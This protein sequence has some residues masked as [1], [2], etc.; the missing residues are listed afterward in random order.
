MTNAS[1][2]KHVEDTVSTYTEEQQLDAAMSEKIAKLLESPDKDSYKT[3]QQVVDTVDTVDCLHNGLSSEHKGSLKQSVSTMLTDASPSTPPSGKP[4]LSP[5]PPDTPCESSTTGSVTSDKPND[6]DVTVASSHNNQHGAHT[7]NGISHTNSLKATFVGSSLHAN[8][9]VFV[10]NINAP[11]FVP[12]SAHHINVASYMANGHTQNGYANGHATGSSPSA[13]SG[14]SPDAAWDEA[15]VSEASGYQNGWY[16]AYGGYADPYTG[17]GYGAMTPDGL[18]VPRQADP[19]W[20]GMGPQQGPVGYQG[21]KRSNGTQQGSKQYAMEADAALA[22][23]REQ[24]PL[25][26]QDSLTDVL[27]VNGYDLVGALDMLA[28]LESE[29]TGQRKQCLQA[30][31]SLDENN[32]PSLATSPGSSPRPATNGPA[33]A[34]SPVPEATAVAESDDTESPKA[35]E[36]PRAVQKLPSVWGSVEGSAHKATSPEKK[37]SGTG[38]VSKGDSM[39]S[40]QKAQAVNSKLQP[41]AASFKSRNK[42]TS[43][44]P[45]VETGAAVSGQYADAR[46]EARD[47]ARLRNMYFQ[48]ATQAYLVGNKALAKE[49]G[50]KG[51]HHSDEM[52]AAHAAASESIFQQRNMRNASSAVSNKNGAPKQ[53]SYDWSTAHGKHRWLPAYI[54]FLPRPRPSFVKGH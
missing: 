54:T 42:S 16:E 17:Y 49:L 29:Q 20:A 38:R 32:F 50:A 26:N 21:R 6:D 48:Q 33:S 37:S 36:K 43:K 15:A 46:E 19:S 14:T 41:S 4:S 53:F 40:Q 39:S 7:H 45:W 34:D 51:R 9:R 5:P 52:K 31:P 10:P 30:P 25:Y 24:F 13:L 47:H 27:K 8:A 12:S 11:A 18:F 44:V 28:Q 23:L 35:A 1:V 3:A 22:V 2:L